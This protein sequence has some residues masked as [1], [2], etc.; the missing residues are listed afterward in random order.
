MSSEKLRKE[1][2]SRID[3]FRVQGELANPIFNVSISQ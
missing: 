1:I 2:E 3:E